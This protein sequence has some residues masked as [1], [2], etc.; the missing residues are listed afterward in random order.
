VTDGDRFWLHVPSKRVVYTGPVVHGGGLRLG[1]E[2]LRLDARALLRALFVEPV[3]A[4]DRLELEE[5]PSAY[6]LSIHR[7]GHLY[8]RLWV[9]RRRFAVEREVYYDA[10]GREELAIRRE[11]QRDVDGRVHPE[12]LVVQ[13][14]L[15]GS[16]ILLE[17]EVLTINPA[18]LDSRAFQPRIPPEARIETLGGTETP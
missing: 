2:D 14:R 11:R 7:D 18:D 12:R 13:D 3:G 16:T 4:A 10:E 6:V 8:R 5:E 1:G 17:F 9:E 15:G